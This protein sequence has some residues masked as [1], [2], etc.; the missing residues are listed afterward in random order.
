[1][2]IRHGVD[3]VLGILCLLLIV[4]GLSHAGPRTVTLTAGEEV[5]LTYLMEQENVRGA[6]QKDDK[7]VPLPA[8]TEDQVLSKMVGQEFTNATRNMDAELQQL[9]QPLK[10]VSATEQTKALNTL[11]PALQTRLQQLLLK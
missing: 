2:W 6:G 1:M 8:L 5:A 4:I 7:G 11:T 3:I 9:I 10:A